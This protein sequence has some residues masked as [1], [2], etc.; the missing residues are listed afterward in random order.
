[1]HLLCIR[2]L[3]ALLPLTL[4]LSCDQRKPLT[5]IADDLQIVRTDLEIAEKSIVDSLQNVTCPKPKHRQ[6]DCTSDMVD[7]V[8]V[9]LA[10]ACKMVTF[11]VPATER[12]INSIIGSINCPCGDQPTSAPGT[13]SRRRKRTRRLSRQTRRLCRVKAILAAITECCEMIT[14]SESTS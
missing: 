5:D 14:P 9:L 3:L 11:D 2:C 10:L 13:R 12:V 6:Q 1:M 7:E 4:A 8:D